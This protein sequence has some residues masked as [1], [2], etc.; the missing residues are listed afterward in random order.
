MRNIFSIHFSF[1]TYK[2]ADMERCPVCNAKYAGNPICHRCK[3]DLAFLTDIEDK[4]R[5]HLQKAKEAF[6]SEDFREMFFHAKRACSLRR[7][8]ETAEMLICASLL[9]ARFDIA[10][11]QWSSVRP[12]EKIK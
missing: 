8:R 1:L 5:E 4:S 7:T 3:S 2:D 6:V 10:L 9:V 11:S 12:T